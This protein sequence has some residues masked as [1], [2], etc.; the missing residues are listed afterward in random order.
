MLVAGETSPLHSLTAGLS[1]PGR[2]F[3]VL[4]QPLPGVLTQFLRA[5]RI[6]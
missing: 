2:L 5:L 4:T 3:N 1:F 6:S